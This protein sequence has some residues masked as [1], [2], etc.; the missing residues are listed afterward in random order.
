[1]NIPSA[2]PDFERRGQPPVVL[3][4][5]PENTH[6][7]SGLPNRAAL[8]QALEF[9]VEQLPGKFAVSFI[10]L[11]GLKAVN[12][13]EGHEEGDKLIIF[14][15]QVLEEDTRSSDLVTLVSHLGGD[16][17]ALVF[18]GVRTEEQ[19]HAVQTRIQ[20]DLYDLGVDAS[21]GGKV[22]EPGETGSDILRA[23]D[24][25]MYHNKIHERKL[26]ALT[27]EQRA[28]WLT[29]GAISKQ[30]DLNLRDGQ[31]IITA[32]LAQLATQE[33]GLE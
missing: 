19:L 9:A 22:H 29:I 5:S 1:M 17:F 8:N 3:P 15:G 32:L 33:N 18:G 27:D 20:T 14:A 16:E 7:L 26:P 6:E 4:W 12:D 21:I 24:R 23:A 28:A 13:D 2:Y 25:Q 30:H 31:T 10:D 11:D